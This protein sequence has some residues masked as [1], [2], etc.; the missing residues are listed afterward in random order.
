MSTERRERALARA[1][2]KWYF[3]R[4][5]IDEGDPVTEATS[6]AKPEVVQTDQPSVVTEY[7]GNQPRVIFKPGV[8]FA[9]GGSI[10]F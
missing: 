4:H 1:T 6:I 8:D 5:G 10:P 3:Y 7:S 9:K 2:Y